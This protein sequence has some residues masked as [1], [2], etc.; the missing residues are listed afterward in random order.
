MTGFC[1]KKDASF[2]LMRAFL[3]TFLYLVRVSLLVFV[4]HDIADQ[5]NWCEP[6]YLLFYMLHQYNNVD[7]RHDFVVYYEI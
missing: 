2:K 5:L 1:G 4:S 7:K 3:I 6:Y